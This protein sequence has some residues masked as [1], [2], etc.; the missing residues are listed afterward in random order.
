MNAVNKILGESEPE[1]SPQFTHT[2]A[3]IGRKKMSNP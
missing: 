1:F 3:L 2:L